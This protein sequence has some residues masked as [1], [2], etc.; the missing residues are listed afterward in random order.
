MQKLKKIDIQKPNIFD[1]KKIE[2]GLT[3][4][5][6]EKFPPYGFSISKANIFDDEQIEQNRKFLAQLLGIDRQNLIIQKQVHGNCANVV[7]SNFPICETDAMI[8]NTKGV[9]LVVSLADCC[10]VLVHDPVKN[11]IAAIHSGWKGTKLNIVGETIRKVV[12]NFRS[13][14]IDMMVWI[15]P[16]AGEKDYEVGWDVAQYFPEYI[17]NKENGKYLLDLK[18]AI[19]NQLKNCGILEN[20]VEISLESTISDFNYHSYRRDKDL[21]GRMGAFIMMK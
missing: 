1:N 17:T 10:G 13:N 3:L 21:S 11:I 14:P 2:A 16:C 7:S 4:R 18:S 20:H 12:E 19:K 9:C 5:N 6:L 15:T 8:T